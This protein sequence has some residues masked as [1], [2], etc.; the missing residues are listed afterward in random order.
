[1]NPIAILSSDGI[2]LCSNEYLTKNAI[3]SK[4]ANPTIHANNFAPMNCSQLI[5][6]L[7]GLATCGAFGARN[8]CGIGGGS[9][10]ALDTAGADAIAGIAAGMTSIF[11]SGAVTGASGCTAEAVC[12]RKL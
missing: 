1:M 11:G 3:P 5:G 6:G 8:S 4:S 2:K 10:V 7:V 9:G 12:G